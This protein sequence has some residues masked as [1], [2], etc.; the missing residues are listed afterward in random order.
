MQAEKFPD[1]T[2]SQQV[3]VRF[4]RTRVHPSLREICQKPKSFRIQSFL[5][6]AE[7]EPGLSRL[8]DEASHSNKQLAALAT[9]LTACTSLTYVGNSHGN[10]STLHRPRSP[11]TAHDLGWLTPKPLAS[12]TPCW[13]HLPSLQ[14]LLS[15]LCQQAALL[16]LPGHQ[17]GLR[18]GLRPQAERQAGLKG[19]LQ[20]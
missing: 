18:A 1:L 19:A 8:H 4:G 3:F 5:K 13:E 6:T 15:C 12:Q 11:R 20:H 2:L 16:C 9:I 17:A 10:H 7:P 14:A